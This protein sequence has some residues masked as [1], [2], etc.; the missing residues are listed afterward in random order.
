MAQETD[1]AVPLPDC[2]ACGG[3]DPAASLV[4]LDTP[5]AWL[6]NLL[7]SETLDQGDLKQLKSTCWTSLEAMLRCGRMGLIV[8]VR[9]LSPSSIPLA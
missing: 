5:K 9:E 1:Q 2:E 8:E 4:L 3:D 6:Q 7:C